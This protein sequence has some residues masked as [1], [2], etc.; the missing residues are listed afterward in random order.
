VSPIQTF[1]LAIIEMLGISKDAVHIYIGIACFLLALTVGRRRPGSFRAL[2]PGLLV[3]IAL[4]VIDLADD[5]LHRGLLIWMPSLKDV[6]NTNLTPL[7]MTLV[8]R[9]TTGARRSHSERPLT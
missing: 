2:L 9:W 1:K 3:S 6:V 7:A 5:Y 8:L 4:E